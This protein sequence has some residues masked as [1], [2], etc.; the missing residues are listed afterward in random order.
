VNLTLST[1]KPRR[2]ARRDRAWTDPL[3]PNGMSLRPHSTI[4]Q[5]AVDIMLLLGLVFTIAFCWIAGRELFRHFAALFD[6]AGSL[7]HEIPI[8]L[9]AVVSLIF[10]VRWLVLQAMVIRCYA[11]SNRAKAPA[12]IDWPF[13]SIMVPAHNEAP[14]IRATVRSLLAI[15]YPHFE[16]LVLDDGSTDGTAEMAR[17]FEGQ[18]GPAICRILTKPNGGKWSAH[19]FGLQHARGEFILCVDADCTFAPNALRMMVRRMNDPAV[20]AVAGNGT[21]RNLSGLL[22]YCQ[23]LEYI[24]SNTAFRIP[25]SETGAVLCVPGPIGLFRRAALD[26]IHARNGEL[27]PGSPPGHFAGPYEHGSIA[28]DFELSIALLAAGWK[29]VYEPRAVCYTEVP[30]TLPGLISQRYRWTR[31]NLQVM[32]KFRNKY[33]PRHFRGGRSALR[34]LLGTYFVEMSCCILFN[35]AFLLLTIALLLGPMANAEFLA[36][37]WTINLLQRGL[38][39]AIAVIIHRER[40][41]LILGWPLYEFYSTLILGGAMVIAAIDQVRGTGVGWGR[42]HRPAG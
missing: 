36:L 33:H 41:R 18:H 40:L 5:A 26:E 12:I 24:Y 32:A 31:G 8:I 10:S 6:P 22:S 17:V 34:W 42:E 39:S 11:R 19:N 20:G 15:D 7:L 30:E 29:I 16:V 2:T 28:E 35:H 3:H 14:S 27:P 38:F 23:G 13:V 9:V 4:A 1:P 37:Y 21:V 25:Q